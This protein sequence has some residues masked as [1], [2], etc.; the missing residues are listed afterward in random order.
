MSGFYSNDVFR[1][2]NAKRITIRWYEWLWLWMFPT[3]VEIDEG[4]AFYFKLTSRKHYL[5][6]AEKLKN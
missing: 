4:Y 6:K 5:I 2:F 3:F 1:E